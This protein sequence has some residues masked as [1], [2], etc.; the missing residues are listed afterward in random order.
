LIPC[1]LDRTVLNGSRP[2]FRIAAFL[3]KEKPLSIFS[4]SRQ[5][6]LTLPLFTGY[7]ALDLQPDSPG[8]V[9]AKFDSGAVTL[10]EFSIGHGKVMLWTSSLDTDWNDL[11]IRP[12]YLP[13]WGEVLE[14]WKM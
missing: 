3:D 1:R 7:V 2:P 5:G 11:P 13:L 6:D 4:Q 8:R 14:F 9:L 10:V 12:I